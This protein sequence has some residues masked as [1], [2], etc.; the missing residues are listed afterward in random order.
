MQ[1]TSEILKTTQINSHT[2]CIDREQKNAGTRGLVI[3]YTEKETE[4]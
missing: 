1:K 4:Q 2:F 3:W